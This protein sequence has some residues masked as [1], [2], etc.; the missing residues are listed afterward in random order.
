MVKPQC[1]ICAKVLSRKSIKPSKLKAHFEAC[2]SNLAGKE[3]DYFKRK[4]TSLKAN[5]ID[6]IG[7]CA[8]QKEAALEASYRITL[9][10]AQTKKP[11]NIGEELIKPCILEATKLILREQQANKLQAISLSNDMVRSRISE[12]SEDILLQVVTAVSKVRYIHCSWTN[13]HMLPHVP[14]FLFMYVTL[15]VKL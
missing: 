11:D 6:S 3:L 13:L 9:R 5:R 10:I 2:H 1:V 8:Q 15:I 4:E 7:R 14:N 12:M